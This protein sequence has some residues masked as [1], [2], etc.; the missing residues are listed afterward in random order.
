MKLTWLFVKYLKI[1]IESKL[2]QISIS[3]DMNHT[4]KIIF[5]ELHTK[6]ITIIQSQFYNIYDEDIG[7]RYA[8]FRFVDMDQVNIIS[9]NIVCYDIL[10]KIHTLFLNY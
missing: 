9:S 8:P 2:L 5:A 7:Y 1:L 3:L 4:D 6:T 10:I